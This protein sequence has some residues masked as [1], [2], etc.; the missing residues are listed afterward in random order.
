M[1][2]ANDLFS[3]S[4]AQYAKFRP[5]YPIEL[6]E[7]LYS[8][9]THFDQAW[10]VGTGSGQVASAL[11][12]RFRHVIATDISALQM[13]YAPALPNVRYMVCRAEQT[14]F[15]EES[16]DLITAAMALH[17]FDCRHFYQEVQRTAKPG[18]LFA[19][20]G[21]GLLEIG[22]HVDEL[23][24]AYYRDVLSR[25][26]DYE[27]THVDSRYQTLPFPFDELECPAFVMRMEWT[28]TQLAGYL[29]TWSAL[30]NYRRNT[31]KDPLPHLIEQIAG[32]WSAGQVREVCFPIF[33]R[34]GIVR[35]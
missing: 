3:E 18:A 10:D 32:H 25:H 16:F 15:P 8:H 29:D 22:P 19:A 12:A 28:L 7:F 5:A 26:W 24:T 4:V 17:W 27:R 6:Y 33:L 1:Q 11:A 9:L 30:R 2:P 34:M 20:W 21:Y 13:A 23:I 14:P 35:R 31:G